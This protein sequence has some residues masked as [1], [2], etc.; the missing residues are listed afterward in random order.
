MQLFLGLC[1]SSADCLLYLALTKNLQM[2][3]IF[4]IED[5]EDVREMIIMVLTTYGHEVTG[6]SGTIDLT[7]KIAAF[8]PHLLLIDVCPG[9]ESGREICKQIKDANAGLPIILMS[10]SAKLL[11]D[12]ESCPADDI[13]EKPFDITE[14]KN[15]IDKVLSNKVERRIKMRYPILPGFLIGTP[16]REIPGIKQIAEAVHIKIGNCLGQRIF[17]HTP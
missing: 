17:A 1:N 12:Y 2:A 10:T 5:S 9:H 6:T 11:V 4:I 16:G 14:L 15:K 7:S 8:N 3:K 13:I